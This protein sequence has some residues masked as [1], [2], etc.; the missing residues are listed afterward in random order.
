ME[1]TN[2]NKPR[3]SIFFPLLV[4]AAGVFLLLNNISEHPYHTGSLL[5]SL[6]PLLFIAGGLDSIYKRE[7]LASPLLFITLGMI[8]LMSNLGYSHLG[9]WHFLIRYWPIIIIAIG[10]DILFPFRNLLVSI[11]GLLVAA[12]VIVG[13][14]YLITT[15]ENYQTRPLTTDRISFPADD[16]DKV[17]IDLQMHAGTMEI[18]SHAEPAI[19]IEGTLHLSDFSRVNEDTQIRNGTGFYSLK[20]GN[21]QFFDI[22][23]DDV[24]FHE[25]NW[26]IQLNQNIPTT[27]DSLLIAGQMTTEL[28]GMDD[29]NMENTVI[30]G[31]NIV[32]LPEKGDV[33]IYSS[34][35]FGELQV[36]VPEEANVII[37]IDTALNSVDIPNGFKKSGSKIFSPNYDAKDNPVTIKVSVPIGDIDIVTQ[38]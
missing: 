37:L 8:L 1:T 31:E 12:A 25:N 16:F 15:D 23:Q 6:W 20:S 13:I 18:G 24:D 35:I 33:D 38:H 32:I 9:S 30:F 14:V 11:V 22:T 17:N 2:N 27:I 34:V 3:Y 7:G 10:L 4:L 29:L 21:F 36:V 5:L 28:T 26:D 19:A